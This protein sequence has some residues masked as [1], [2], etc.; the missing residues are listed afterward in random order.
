MRSLKWVGVAVLAIAITAP[1][2]GA[3][4]RSG[5]AKPSRQPQRAS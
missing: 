4:V 1:Q 2:A 3:T 5:S